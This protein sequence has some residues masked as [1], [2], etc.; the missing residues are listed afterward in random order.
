MRG[1]YNK[2]LETGGANLSNEIKLSA[3]IETVERTKPATP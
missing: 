3:D 1:V 2:V